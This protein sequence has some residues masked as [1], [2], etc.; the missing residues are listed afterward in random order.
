MSD[1]IIRNEVRN[2]R[3]RGYDLQTRK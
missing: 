2:V 3:E 1:K